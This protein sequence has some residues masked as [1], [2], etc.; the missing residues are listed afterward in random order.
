IQNVLEFDFPFDQYSFADITAKQAAYQA[1]HGNAT[2]TGQATMS[3]IGNTGA[4]TYLVSQNYPALD[5]YYQ[6]SRPA[7]IQQAYDDVGRSVQQ[8]ENGTDH[9]SQGPMFVIGGSVVG[10]VY[11]NHPN[12]DDVDDEGNTKY[13]QDGLNDFRSTDFRDV[14]GTIMKHWLNMP[15]STII[16]P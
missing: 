14:Y 5:G 1:L 3:Y 9:G 6:S 4:A 2:A 13:S 12:L 8:N 7:P 11:G 15:D 16:D 10:G